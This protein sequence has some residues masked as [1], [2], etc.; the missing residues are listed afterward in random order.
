MEY[1]SSLMTDHENPLF[2]ESTLPYQLPPFDRVRDAH[3][4]PAFARAMA[5]HLREVETVAGSAEAPTFENTIVALERSG[6]MLHR[7][8]RLFFNLASAHTNPAIQ[9]VES[10]IAPKLSAHRDAI[11]LNAALF[12]RLESLLAR[13][14]E[15]GL[16]AESRYLLERYE[17]DFV[18]AGARLA[19]PEKTRLKALN[20]ELAS[21]Q[22]TFNQSVLKEKN[23]GSV[24][25]DNPAQL[26]GLTEAEIA[27]AA[28]DAKDENHAGAFVLRLLNTTGQPALA[29]LQ[30]RALRR[31][32]MEASL[33]RNSSGGEF[34]TREVVCRIAKLR[35]ERA[36]LLGY[37]SHAA[38]QLEDQTAGSVEAVNRL[39]ADLAGPAIA[40][41]RREAAD[42]QAIVDQENG[43]FSLAP[44]DWAYYSEKVRKARYALDEAQLRPYFELERVLIDGVFYAAT[45]LFGITFQERH[46]LPVYHPDVRVF[47]VFDANGSPLALFLV[48]LYARPSKRGGA[49]M[50]AYVTQSDLLG[51]RPVIGNHMNVVKPPA[52]EPTLLT[53]EEVRT[54]FHEFGHALHGLFSRVMYP[55]FSGTTVPR[56]FV[57]FPSQ[58]NEMWIDWPEVI[59]NYAHHYE[60]GEPIPHELLERM[61]AAGKFN[62][63]F[64]TTEYLAASLLDQAWHQLAP[65]EAPADVLAFEAAALRRA[66]VDFSLVPPRYRSPYFSHIFGGGYSAGYYSYI[67]SEVMDADG[68]EWISSHGGLTRENGDHL[69]STVLSRGGSAPALDLFRDFA[70]GAPRIEPLLRRRGL[71]KAP[72]AT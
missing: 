27:A 42:M 68:V 35:A 10:A 56:D 18:R 4:E 30:D 50:N 29:S 21:L 43:G 34:D 3:Y 66:G 16:D 54:A 20:A 39:L 64:R 72:A 51:E 22:T 33:A 47:E 5:D 71:E 63:G 6:Q 62:Q 9:Q 55:R 65:G 17:K 37:P 14:D 70:G 44:W 58:I 53:S 69:R 59:K 8:N 48:D 45:R 7:I 67:W 13:K 1:R 28:A 36:A 52:G 15:L 60:T 41:A 61:E 25:V 26:A 49:W 24:V 12:G 57:E 2:G 11:Y 31:R 32:L 46:D 19:G 38:Y 23:A 40:N